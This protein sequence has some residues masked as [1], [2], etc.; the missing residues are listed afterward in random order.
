MFS[1]TKNLWNPLMELSVRDWLEDVNGL[2]V[3]VLMTLL[4]YSKAL[5]YFRGNRTVEL[6][7]LRQILGHPVTDPFSRTYCGGGVLAACR[8][9][10]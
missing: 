5:A 8:T 3:R 6:E 2:S 1:S 10:L 4:I 9:A 7:D